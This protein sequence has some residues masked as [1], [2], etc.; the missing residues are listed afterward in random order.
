MR[1]AA[2]FDCLT[3]VALATEVGR[4]PTKGEVQLLSYLASLLAVYDRKGDGA[5]AWGYT[6]AVTPSGA[7]FSAE[8]AEAVDGLVA[9]G[10][11]EVEEGALRLSDMGQDLHAQL[12]ELN[13][14]RSRLGYLDSSSATALVL[15]LGMVRA[16]LARSPQV[17]AV[18]AAQASREMFSESG[19]ARL[20]EDFDAVR[21]VLGPGSGSLFAASVLWLNYLLERDG[22]GIG[23]RY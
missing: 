3:V 23:E 19:L 9:Q 13:L 11:L 21:G 5:S 4:G 14:S 1:I 17:S 16:A 12:T 22:E 15:P 8:V 2:A 10:A 20:Y 6:F 18:V 7:P